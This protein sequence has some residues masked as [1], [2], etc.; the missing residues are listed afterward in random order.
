MLLPDTARGRILTLAGV[1]GEPSGAYRLNVWR[2]TCQLV[3]ASP[4]VG[5]G[6]G[7]YESALP[8]F[9][10]GAGHLRVEHAENGYLEFLAEAGAIGGLLLGAL[11]SLV[12]VMGL[13]GTQREPHRMARALRSS[14]AAGLACLLVHEA[15]DFNL[16]IPSNALFA[17]GLLALLIAPA[18]RRGSGVFSARDRLRAIALGVVVLVTLFIAVATPWEAPTVGSLARVTRPPGATL[19]RSALEAQLEAALRRRPADAGDWVRL[20][21]LRMAQ[22]RADAAALSRWGAG[23]DPE[24]RGLC[25]AAAQLQGQ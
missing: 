17:A 4:I 14:A 19:R 2:D 25:R 23:L 7:A 13:R 10:T 18:L 6:L 21:W 24:N 9:K 8:R 15:F 11:V 22:S 1:T 3:A 16:R 5:F 20:G 12:G